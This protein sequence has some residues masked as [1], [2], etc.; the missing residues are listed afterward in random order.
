MEKKGEKNR[1]AALTVGVMMVITLSG[2]ILG[3][4]R[5]RLLTV[6]YGSGSEANAFL[7]ASRIPRVF[8]DT[9]FTSS[10]AACLIPV[11]GEVLQKRG[12]KDALKFAGNFMTVMGIICA[13]VTLLGVIFA[14]ALTYFFADGFDAQTAALCAGLTRIMMPTVFFTGVAFCFVGILQIFDEFNVP[15]AISLISN[16]VVII[17]YLTLN[18]KFGV[19]GLAVAFLV[20]WAVQA[21]VQMPSLKKK[22]FRF[23]PSLSVRNADMDKV[24]RLLLPSMVSTWVL[25]IMQ[26]VNSK[27]GSRL[28][29]G[30][31]VSAIEYSYSLYTVI[32]G[33]FVLQVTNYIFPKLS[34]QNAEGDPVQL[35]RT[36]RSTMH[37]TLFVVIPMTAGLFI[38]AEPIVAF[39]YGG[40][41]FDQFSIDITSRALRFISLGMIG[42]AIQYVLSRAFFAAQSGKEPLFAGIV[43]IVLDIVLCAVLAPRFDVAGIAIASAASFT[44]N[45][46]FMSVPLQ[47]RGVGYWDREFAI[48]MLKIS[49]S[50]VVMGAAAWGTRVLIAGHVGKLLAVCVPTAVGVAVYAVCVLALRVDEARQVTGAI[51][52]K[53]GKGAPE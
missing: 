22:G 7:T 36:L 35:R 28:F 2:K 9:V 24:W 34:K 11:M 5:D 26:T 52:K 10:I 29:G 8:F 37:T 14:D 51:K 15:A 46:L 50:A 47:R 25:P 41:R 31:G 12:K 19:Y 42:Y 21:L 48:D 23:Y 40:G 20:A 27:F 43:S 49:L 32:A 18:D 17:Y 53:L 44:A 6:N 4:L 45:G 1:S 3:L 30:A 33:I 13:A 16:V 39:I 38:M